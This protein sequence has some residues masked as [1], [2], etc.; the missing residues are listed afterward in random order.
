M[1]WFIILSVI[2]LNRPQMNF[3]KSLKRRS[4]STA[5]APPSKEVV[6]VPS[7][8]LFAKNTYANNSSNIGALAQQPSAQL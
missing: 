4:S 1:E 3:F 8:D 6:K 7:S 2:I 5:K